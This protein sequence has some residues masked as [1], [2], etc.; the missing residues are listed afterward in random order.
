MSD[1]LFFSAILA[2][3][4]LMV[5]VLAVL[6]G[7][8]IGSR[9]TVRSERSSKVRHAK[10]SP[11][12]KRKSAL[13]RFFLFLKK[14]WPKRK[15]KQEAPAPAPTPQAVTAEKNQDGKE[16]K[17]KSSLGVAAAIIGVMFSLNAFF[18]FSGATILV[19]IVS[20]VSQSPD[21]LKTAT[22]YGLVAVSCGVSLMLFAVYLIKK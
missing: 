8:L 2:I 3:V 20:I 12:R 7:F 17:K 1:Q 9:N 10:K 22:G 15:K 18:V 13:K 11:P 16:K 19:V 14:H 5:V 21:V 4:A 6:L